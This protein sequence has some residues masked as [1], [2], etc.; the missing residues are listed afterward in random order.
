[1]I[2]PQ[3][4]TAATFTFRVIADARFLPASVREILPSVVIFTYV[5]GEATLDN[6]TVETKINLTEISGTWAF[7][8]KSAAFG[9]DNL[10]STLNIAKTASWTDYRGKVMWADGHLH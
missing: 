7:T 4:E 9:K 8:I 5:Y 2:V 1:V 3:L 6:S 10:N